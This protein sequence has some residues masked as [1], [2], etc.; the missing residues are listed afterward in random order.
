M[1]S[2]FDEFSER[3]YLSELKALKKVILEKK[4]GLEIGVGTGRF[5]S[6]LGIEYGIDPSE[7]ML[8]IAK[9]RGVKV[10]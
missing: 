7:K 1:K 10:S 3:T 5:A 2:V 9:K 4:K 6:P 8:E